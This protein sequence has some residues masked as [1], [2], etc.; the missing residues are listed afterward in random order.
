MRY[1]LGKSNRAMRYTTID[2]NFNQVWTC[3]CGVENSFDVQV[4]RWCGKRRPPQITL[5]GKTR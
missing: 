4:C 3:R 5:D 2:S 1:G